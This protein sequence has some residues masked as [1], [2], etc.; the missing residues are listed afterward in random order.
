MQHAL[1]N[2]VSVSF[3]YTGSDNKPIGNVVLKPGDC[4]A[5]TS[6]R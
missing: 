3:S 2:G 1:S 5:K 6:G 4:D